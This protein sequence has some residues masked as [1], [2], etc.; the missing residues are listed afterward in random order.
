MANNRSHD[1]ILLLSSFQLNF[2]YQMG[3]F[4]TNQSILVLK[5]FICQSIGYLFTIFHKIG[6]AGASKLPHTLGVV[7]CFHI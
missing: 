5:S 7:G 4:V 1:F 6:N 2:P 3:N